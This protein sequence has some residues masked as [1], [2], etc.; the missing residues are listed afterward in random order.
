MNVLWRYR[1]Q[2]ASR[3]FSCCCRCVLFLRH[4][5]RALFALNMLNQWW[6][7][8]IMGGGFVGGVGVATA[9]AMWFL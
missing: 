2:F 3:D 4:L 8:G 5:R 1:Q 7:F 6:T 9:V